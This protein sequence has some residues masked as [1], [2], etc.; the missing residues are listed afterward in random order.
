MRYV[1]LRDDDTNALTPPE[2]LEQLYRPFLDRGMPV[3]L[4]VIPNVRT[5][6]TYGDNIL[7]GFLLTRNGTKQAHHA[8]RP[9]PSPACL[10]A[11]QSRVSNRAARLQ[12]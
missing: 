6:I 7:E 2:Y 4:A 10:L 5:D 8:D 11:G 12:S 3:N 1:I 9:Q